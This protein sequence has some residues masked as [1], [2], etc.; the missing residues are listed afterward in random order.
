MGKPV[1]IYDVHGGFG[2][3][4][5]DN[6]DAAEYANFSG[7]GGTKYSAD[8]LA[9]MLVNDWHE[10]VKWAK[11]NKLTM[12]NKFSLDNQLAEL[13]DTIQKRECI[14]LDEISRNIFIDQEMFALRYYRAWD[15]ENWIKNE[16]NRIINEY[17]DIS[18]S[19]EQLQ[20]EY[21]DLAEDNNKIRHEYDELN[22][23]N[24]Q[25]KEEITKL[26]NA[27]SEAQ[28][29]VIAVRNSHSYKIGNKLIAP[30]TAIKN[31]I[32]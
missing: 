20:N 15:Y 11:E 19:K 12:A 8:E 16:H 6:F 28:N 31:I 22:D 3:L 18:R 5:K 7:R 26:Q 21:N 32:N 29:E 13:L 1:F 10:A 30:A 9:S 23:V 25:L 24:S 17:E 27:L 4:T 2:Y 14:S